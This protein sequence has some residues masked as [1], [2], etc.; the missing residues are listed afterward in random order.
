MSRPLEHVLAA[1]YTEPWAIEPRR[2][3]VLARVVQRRATGVRLTNQEI[4]EAVGEE[5]AE[6]NARLVATQ[7]VNAARAGVAVVPIF[8]VL[9][10]RGALDNSSGMTS[11]ELVHAKLRAAVA[12]PDVQTIL[13]DVDSPGGEVAGTPELAEFIRGIEKPVVACA[14]SMACSAAFW[15]ATAADEL[16]VTPS[17]EVGSVGVL[18]IH[19]DD[20]EQLAAEG[21][22]RTVIAEPEHK[23][24]LW[25]ALT[26]EAKEWLEQRARAIYGDFVNAL[27]R[28]RGVSAATV[29][30]KFGGGRIVSARDALAAAMVDRVATFEA[31]LE[32]LLAGGRVRR[33]ASAVAD[34]RA[35]L[36]LRRRQAE[37]DE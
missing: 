12:D 30:E 4:Q 20:T 3:A 28:N 32:R 8:G 2:G 22:T 6:M 26:P 21:I 1:V 11:L 27:A 34:P 10:H 36:D 18:M 23:G 25:S 7:R 29:R 37:A 33:R 16:V 9:V 17:G 13:L 19:E 15:I 5:R 35:E 24:E 14:N 31:T